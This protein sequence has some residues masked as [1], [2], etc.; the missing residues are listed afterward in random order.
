MNTLDY[1]TPV[2]VQIRKD[3]VGWREF[4]AAPGER[5][6]ACRYYTPYLDPSD[7]RYQGLCRNGFSTA[8]NNTCRDWKA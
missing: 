7:A 8:R 5:C 3:S 4:A 1:P 6:A 2:P